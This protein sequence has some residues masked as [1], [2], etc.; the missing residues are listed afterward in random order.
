MEQVKHR[1]KLAL[2]GAMGSGKSRLARN[3]T[4]KYG[5]T[6]I[7]TDAEFTRRYGSISDFF[8]SHG[9]AEFRRIEQ[10]LLVEA[11][12]SDAAVIATGGGAV[13]NKVG[14]N[15]LRRS[16]DIVYLTAPIEILGA[17]IKA[18]DRPLKND[19]AA[20]FESREPLYKRYAD[21]TVDSSVDSLAE[22]EKALKKP[23]KNRYDVVLCDS[24]DTILDFKTA[25]KHSIVNAVRA[26]G[27]TRADDEIAKV[28]GE[29]TDDVWKRL[30]RGEITRSELDSMRF[31]MLRDRLCA[32]FDPTAVGRIY[33][34]EMQKTRY[35][36]D[37]AVEFLR[38]LRA[39][40]I[41]VYI[42]TNGFTKIASERLKAIDGEIDGAFISEQIGYNKPD[43][44]FFERVAAAVG[45]LDKNRTVVFGDSVTSDIAGGMAF[46]ADTCLLDP[47][48]QKQTY[49]DYSVTTYA[50]LLQTV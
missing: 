43:T 33:V 12:Q 17:R 10:E 47:T 4:A 14:M 42:I 5:G 44:R 45:G 46:G 25:M 49:A 35:V 13:L 9:E 11:A 22:L 31:I 34:A 3:L 41:K 24:D 20:I 40:G 16:C 1:K 8:A 28:Y 19:F 2:I 15:A 30:E 37:G 36:L 48:G 32:D 27:V 50:E 21:Y 29:I 6:A 39:R 26:A 7:D 38:D 23:R 18:S